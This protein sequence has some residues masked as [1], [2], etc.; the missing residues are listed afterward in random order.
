MQR[1]RVPNFLSCERE[2]F[3]CRC[4]KVQLEQVISAGKFENAGLLACLSSALKLV[5]EN[6]SGLPGSSAEAASFIK[7]LDTEL[8][9]SVT[10]LKIV[11]GARLDNELPCERAICEISNSSC[12]KNSECIVNKRMLSCKAGRLKSL[13]ISAH[14]AIRSPLLILIGLEEQLKREMTPSP[15]LIRAGS[16]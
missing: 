1:A 8:V 16:G 4:V 13:F 14:S 10:V 15:V 3:T 7:S 5:F 6:L 2:N 9:R 12:A 11:F